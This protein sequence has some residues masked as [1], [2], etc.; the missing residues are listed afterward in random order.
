M[1][2]C[3][4]E[5]FV[6]SDVVYG[7]ERSTRKRFLLASR[8]E[9]RVHG[10]GVAWSTSIDDTPG[11]LVTLNEA[12]IDIN[13]R[14]VTNAVRARLALAHLRCCACASCPAT[15][16]APSSFLNTQP[17]IYGNIIFTHIGILQGHL[18]LASNQSFC[19]EIHRRVSCIQIPDAGEKSDSVFLF[20][21]II[22]YYLEILDKPKRRLLMAIRKAFTVLCRTGI[23]PSSLNVA[24]ADTAAIICCRYRTP[25]DETIPPPLFVASSTRSCYFASAPIVS[26]GISSWIELGAN[27][28]VVADRLHPVEPTLSKFMPDH[29]SLQRQFFDD[30]DDDDD[31]TEDLRT[32]NSEQFSSSSIVSPLAKQPKMKIEPAS[33][34]LFNK[35]QQVACWLK[36]ADTELRAETTR[37][38]QSIDAPIRKNAAETKIIANAKKTVLIKV[39]QGLNNL[40]YDTDFDRLAR[41]LLDDA[42]QELNARTLNNAPDRA[43]LDACGLGVDGDLARSLLKEL[44]RQESHTKNATALEAL[45][46][47]QAKLYDA[48]F[49]EAERAA[50]GL[51][52]AGVE[53]VKDVMTAE[54]DAFRCALGL[55]L[56]KKQESTHEKLYLV[57]F[58]AGDGRFCAEFVRAADALKTQLFVV[59]YEVSVGALR[60]LKRRC[61]KNL[62]YTCSDEVS[63][64][65]G[66]VTLVLCQGGPLENPTQVCTRLVQCLPEN[67]NNFDM[68]LSGWGSTS[69]IPDLP[70]QPQRQL[71]FDTA[72]AHLAPVLLQIVSSPNNFLKP[73]SEFQRLRFST[74]TPG[75]I[76]RL[77]LATTPG[78]FYYP[79]A[80]HEYF[81]TAVSAQE[82][83]ERLLSAGFSR[84]HLRACNVAS[85]RDLTN[86][87]VLAKLE[88]LVLFYINRDDKRALE[89]IL[90][91]A[92][93]TAAKR[94]VHWGTRPLRRCSPLFRKDQTLIHQLARYIISISVSFINTTTDR[95]RQ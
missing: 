48:R 89:A 40:N 80:E 24:A 21:L 72:F 54:R 58:G 6:L 39:R 55:A 25:G 45:A 28:V 47:Q 19:N 38:I 12:L 20:R 43:Q 81:Y 33:D 93:A 41:V 65:N 67:T 18:H 87:P 76:A 57:D 11:I 64:T 13:V 4:E 16:Y 56:Y 94:G 53:E 82:E 68:V 79:V 27:E 22:S 63:L 59:A 9:E 84:I 75:T 44:S 36:K 52:R 88:T 26:S 1:L 32:L 2:I 46:L 61:V 66:K 50:V 49:E 78:S 70:G 95:R 69:A 34:H 8:G 74:R 14:R 83:H 7:R 73:Q 92:V 23:P 42:L 29:V 35:R 77:R 85:F 17:F 15:T 3:S 31:D 86:N 71:A 51:D 10:F 90:F 91:R 62:G 60:A 30:N 5:A 37:L